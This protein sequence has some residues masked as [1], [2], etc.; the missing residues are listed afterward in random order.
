M[1]KA[2]LLVLNYIDMA[3]V[4]SEKVVLEVYKQLLDLKYKDPAEEIRPVN[5]LLSA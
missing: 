1:W 2:T 5:G 4:Q 3:R